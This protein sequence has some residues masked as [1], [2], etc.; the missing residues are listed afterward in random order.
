MLND[1]LL[2]QSPVVPLPPSIDTLSCELISFQNLFAGLYNRAPFWNAVL[3]VARRVLRE[4]V[5]HTTHGRS[6]AL[7]IVRRVP[8]GMSL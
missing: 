6:N 3:P 2:W 8:T 1:Q 4:R 5:V 7:T